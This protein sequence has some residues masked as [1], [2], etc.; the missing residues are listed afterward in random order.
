MKVP[1]VDLKA[2]YDALRE[3]IDGAIRHIVENTAFIGGEAV[4]GFEQ[5]FAAFCGAA[6][7]IGL[8]NGTDAIAIT[9]KCLGIGA[10][11]EV[12]CPANSFIASSEAITLA[13]AG[14][15]FVEVDER[16]QT[17]D[18]NLLESVI[19]P[20]TR[21][22]LPVHLYGRPADMDALGEIAARHSLAVIED[23]A[24]AHGA[25]YK[26]RRV[27]TLGRAAC[28]SFY[29]GKNLGAYGDGGAVVTDDDDLALRIRMFKNH[30]RVSKYDHEF[31]GTNSRLDG[32]QAAILRAK[33]PHL[34]AWS[35]ARYEHARAYNQR[36][37]DVPGLCCPDL[38]EPGG[39][40]FHLFV[41]RTPRRDLLLEGLRKRGIACGVHYPIALPNLRA[42]G[43]LGHSR[44]DFPL[45][46]RHQ[47]EV[48][49]LPIFPELTAAQRDHVCDTVEELV[50]S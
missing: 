29:P 39:H 12:I 30:G 36:L 6:H 23:A 46:S 11:D 4:S 28:F 18:P 17:M 31:E 1:F 49:S 22:I 32:L 14:V 15:V 16:T 33:L 47:D 20:R 40:V 35:A 3:D 48:I 50:A 34:S 42:Y 19:T 5:E 13:G 45:S 38:P 7:C 10:G 41:V 27:G 25:L 8:G 37:A 26:G 44:E 2:Q 9:L 43:Y 21:A 24:Q